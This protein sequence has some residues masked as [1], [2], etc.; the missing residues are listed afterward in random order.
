MF[1]SALAKA[2][3]YGSSPYCNLQTNP[4]SYACHAWTFEGNPAFPL[5]ILDWKGQLMGEWKTTTYAN[6]WSE[7]VGPEFQMLV[8]SA[9]P[10]IP[11]GVLNREDNTLMGNLVIKND[12]IYFKNWRGEDFKSYKMSEYMTDSFTFKFSFPDG[13]Y[14]QSFICRDFNR[15]NKHHLMCSWF[16]IRFYANGT[17]TYEH[18]AYFGF[19]KAGDTGGNMP[20][21]NPP[22][23]PA[24]PPYGTS[25]VPPTPLPPVTKPPV[26]PTP[27]AN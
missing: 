27:P 6:P 10:R 22:Q 15:N 26:P 5:N 14:E 8:D 19:T 24:Q 1:F 17:Y 16:L 13:D 23:P 21:P 18:H 11:K 7:N 12:R 9:N 2:Q 4:H 3:Y 20:V 25:P